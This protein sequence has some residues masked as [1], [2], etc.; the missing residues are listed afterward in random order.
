MTP[1]KLRQR[2]QNR[3]RKVSFDKYEDFISRYY[4]NLI[5]Q[6]RLDDTVDPDHACSLGL[7]FKRIKR[8]FTRG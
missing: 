2:R 8:F 5:M 7:I 1:E 3:T 4:D 6:V